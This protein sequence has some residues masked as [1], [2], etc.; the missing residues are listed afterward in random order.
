[1]I[2]IDSVCALKDVR[3][4]I[5]RGETMGGPQADRRQTAGIIRAQRRGQETQGAQPH[6]RAER[7]AGDDQ[8]PGG[9]SSGD[10]P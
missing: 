3:F 4:E 5:R 8:G 10:L 9:Q 2:V 1:M 6:H 7:R